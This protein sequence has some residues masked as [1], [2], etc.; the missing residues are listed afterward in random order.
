M[1]IVQ[2]DTGGN[3]RAVEIPGFDEMSPGDQESA[4]SGIHNYLT[5]QAPQQPQTAQPPGDQALVNAVPQASPDTSYT[6]ALGFG[7][8]NSAE[9][10]GKTADLVGQATGWEGAEAAGKALE[11]ATAAPANYQP[12]DLPGALRRGDYSAFFSSLPRAAVESAPDLAAYLG[13]GAVAG[14]AGVAGIAAV[15]NLGDNVAARAANNDDPTPTGGD[16]IGGGLTT[17]GQ[18]ALTAIGIGRAG[19]WCR[20]ARRRSR[21]RQANRGRWSGCSRRRWQRCR[22]PDWHDSRHR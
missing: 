7:I 18:A 5:S 12:T 19:P 6:G 9:G 16:W 22:W 4:V 14:P 2:I 11:G 17:A 13:A 15:R 21:P 20:S 3:V 10:L 1:A 8:H